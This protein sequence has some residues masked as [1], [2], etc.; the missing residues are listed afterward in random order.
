MSRAALCLSMVEVNPWFLRSAIVSNMRFVRSREIPK[1]T[2]RPCWVVTVT[3]RRF[4]NG[5]ISGVWPSRS[6]TAVFM[7]DLFIA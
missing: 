7:L 5:P 3:P 4:F 6:K 1:V 2:A